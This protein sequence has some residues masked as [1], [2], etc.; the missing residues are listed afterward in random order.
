MEII[1]NDVRADA[2]SKIMAGKKEAKHAWV[3]HLI[4]PIAEY[5]IEKIEDGDSD[6]LAA[7]IAQE[8]KTY[9]K[10]IDFVAKQ[11]EKH[12]NGRNTGQVKD[13]EVYLM[14][15]D[16]FNKDDAEIERQQAEDDAAA[17]LKKKEADEKRKKANE[18]AAA[19]RKAAKPEEPTVKKEE[20]KVEPVKKSTG[21]NVAQDQMSLADL[22]GGVA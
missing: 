1:N 6:E 9:Q 4:E 21:K 16:Y 18:E 3:F 7:K 11:C 20:K 2:I 19:K 15:L 8:H 12:L 13:D 22:M 10:C 17:A 14:S 5:L